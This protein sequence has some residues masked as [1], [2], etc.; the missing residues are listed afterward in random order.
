M[1]GRKRGMLSNFVVC[2]VDQVLMGALQMKHLALRQ[3]ALANKVV[4]IDECHA[5]DMY[6]RQY[7]EDVL[8]WLGSWHVPVVLL[9]ATLPA[10][11]REGMLK[12]YLNG[13]DARRA[14]RRRS[15]RRPSSTPCQ[16]MMSVKEKHPHEKNPYPIITY[17]DGATMKS[18]PV[19]SATC[20]FPIELRSVDDNLDNLLALIKDLSA[21][22]GCIGVICD[23]VTRAQAAAEML[24]DEFGCESVTLTH[25]RFTDVDRMG[26]ETRLREMLGPDASLENGKR[27][28]FH[29]VVGTQVLEQS[30]DIDFDVLVTDVAPVDLLLQRMGRCHRHIRDDRPSRLTKPRC[31][32][33]GIETWGEDGPSF[34]SGISDVY[35][36]ASLIESLSVC[37][38]V[39][40]GASSQ[41]VLPG[42]IAALVQLAYSDYAACQVPDR[43]K[44]LYGKACTAREENR[45]KKRA[46]ARCCLLRPTDEMI[47]EG[48][49]LT[50]WYQLSSTDRVDGDYGPRAVRD[51]QETV[52]VMLLRR[53]GNQIR[54][55]PWVGDVDRGIELGAEIPVDVVPDRDIAMLAIQSCVRLPLSICAMERIEALIGELEKMDGPFVGAWQ[56][57]SWLAGEL[58]LFLEEKDGELETTL[59][60]GPANGTWQIRYARDVGLTVHRVK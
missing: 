5:Y 52:E 7:L 38:I 56:E 27:P 30:L 33:R 6:M 13:R 40:E 1:T 26:N 25:A 47:R 41:L 29:I 32:I 48:L 36:Q 18:H 34:A 3:L 54:L 21:E 57:S 39:G 44:P 4:I 55:L 50:D 20:P 12:A 2:T 23:T 53:I 9:S 46:R 10:K 28:R 16:S 19:E 51:T 37:R 45:E 15:L 14:T 49:S 58:A 31:Y 60:L 22:G 17:S 42:D 8:G 59:D 24:S 43:W 35:G 11:Q